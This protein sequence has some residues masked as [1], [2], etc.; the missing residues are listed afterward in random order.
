MTRGVVLSVLSSVLFAV[1]YYYTTL[2]H[3]LD[4]AEIFAWRILLCLP[5]VAVLL[6]RS[7]GWKEVA[8]VFRR[9]RHEWRLWLLLPLS[10]ALIGAQLWLFVWAPLHQRAMDVSMGYFLLPLVMVL[11]GRVLYQEKLNR[12]QTA[13]VFVA[14]LGV[15]HELMRTGT[16]SWVTALVM[17]GYPPYFIVRRKLRMGSLSTLWF[18]MMLM[19]PAALL[20]LGGQ[21]LGVI[22][23]FRQRPALLG[24]VP[25]LGAISSAALIAYLTA[26]RYLPLGLFGLL[27]YVEPVLLFWVALLFLS[28]EVPAAAWLTYVPIWMAVALVAVDGM[29]RIRPRKR[30]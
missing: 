16:F 15:A 18:D 5:A 17:F 27:G 1:L 21:D 6:A 7:R 2:L 8:Q 20:I 13:A 12:L 22:E 30:V 3:P 23:Q 9:L 14:A 25:V 10:S 29:K 11:I 26:S 24:L 19:V 28:E 4:G